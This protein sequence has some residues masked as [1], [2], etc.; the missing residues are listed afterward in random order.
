MLGLMADP[1]ERTEG[2]NKRERTR[3]IIDTEDEIRL[4]VRLRALKTRQ[5]NSAVVNAI[6][7]EALAAEIAEVQSYPQAGGSG[8]KPGPK[9][10]EKGGGK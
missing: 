1:S 6:L 2:G 8:K 9:R 10:K 4:A 3:L 7:R 5:D